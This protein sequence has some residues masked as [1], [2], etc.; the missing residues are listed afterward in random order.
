MIEKSSL[1]LITYS[2]F[3]LYQFRKHVDENPGH[4]KLKVNRM[5]LLTRSIP[6]HYVY[7]DSCI[8]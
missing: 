6:I 1:F 8:L 7:Q 4:M 3:L 2:I 5:Y